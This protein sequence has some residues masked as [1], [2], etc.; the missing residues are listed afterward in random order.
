[1]LLAVLVGLTG[2]V[3]GATAAEPTPAG[4]G[5]LPVLAYYYQWF[6]PSS[7]NRVKID[8]PSLGRYSS[9]DENVMRRHIELAR[10]AGIEGFIV[11]WKSSRTNDRRLRTLMDVARTENFKL[12]VIYQGLDFERRPL[13]VARIGA[14][15]N[16]F[17]RDFAGDGVF[18]I[19]D[20]PLVLWSGTWEF[21]AADIERVTRPLR[22]SL[23]ILATEKSV[24]GYE[25]VAASFDGNAY[26]W[27]S[28]D[29]DSND[30]HV[31]KLENMGRAVHAR[32]GLW[33]A[34]FAPGFD[35]RLVGG[36][37]TV[38]R[39]DGAT[40]RSEYSAAVRSSPDALGL[41]SWNEF[42]E[43]THVEPSER[44]G[45][46][47]LTVL[48]E[49]L[50]APPVPASPLAQ[51]SSEQ[52]GSRGPPAGVVALAVVALVLLLVAGAAAVRRSGVVPV[53]APATVA[54]P[55]PR[56]KQKRWRFWRKGKSQALMAVALLALLAGGVAVYAVDAAQQPGPAP[57]AA[58]T[59]YGGA[60]PVRNPADV[61]VG[62]AGDIAC[63]PDA[64]GLTE[65]KGRPNSCRMADTAALV[66]SLRPDAVLA[67]GDNQYPDGSLARFR[68]SYDKTW[69]TFKRITYPVPGNHDY[70]TND[71]TGYFGYFGAAAGSRTAGYY[72]YDLGGWHVIALNSECDN[73]GG[74][75]AGSPQE[76]WLRRD[77]AAHPSACTLAYWHRPRFSSG[78]HGSSRRYDAFWRALDAAGADVVLSAHDHGYER[79]GPVDPEGAPRPGNGITQFVV[80]TGGN[81]HYKFHEPVAGSQ[82]RL[83]GRHGVLQLRLRPGSFS[84]N[85][86]TTDA[87]SGDAGT[88]RCH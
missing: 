51:D 7:W 67:L 56:R 64:A 27:S 87:G 20:R 62:A 19:F 31:A 61:V 25:R 60:K 84:W 43:N 10:A 13:P 23:R 15:L 54:A 57:P 73:V 74:C 17:A 55:G 47:S 21:S 3:T 9:D 5:H 79:I 35:A 24:E 18:S 42:S 38:D 86:L 11:S 28:V 59:F 88:A 78:T 30:N 68:G 14:D 53:A 45:D 34:P 6:N 29:P 65:E 22:S 48:G 70:G 37:Q 75:A 39:K 33:I 44:Y 52:S 49:I 50:R 81:S 80:G 72:S 77:L 32:G 58:G 46:R 71:A 2:P 12:A 16:M 63:P 36:S 69:G 8:Y 4:T 66:R 82:A 85:F 83:A 76:R 41:I 40:L 26:Y 1:V